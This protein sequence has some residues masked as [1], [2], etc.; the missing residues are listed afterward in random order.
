MLQFDRTNYK[1][2]P[3]QEMSSSEMEAHRS[4]LV[5]FAELT[6]LAGS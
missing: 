5:S 3:D 4:L 2:V 6:Q 1:A